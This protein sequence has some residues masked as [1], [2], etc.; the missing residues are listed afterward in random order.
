MN[1]AQKKKPNTHVF[2]NVSTQ[3]MVNLLGLTVHLS[4]TKKTKQKINKN[5]LLLLHVRKKNVK[6]FLKN[7]KH[8][9]TV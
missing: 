6:E 9:G 8:P 5:I 1:Y 3:V 2:D 7:R 4:E